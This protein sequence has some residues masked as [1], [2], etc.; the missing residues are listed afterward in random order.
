MRFAQGSYF[1]RPGFDNIVQTK[2]VMNLSNN[3]RTGSVKIAG[4]MEATR[5]WKER[6]SVEIIFKKYEQ[7]IN[8]NYSYNNI[9]FCKFDMDL[10]SGHI[11]LTI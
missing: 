2:L 5:Y 7:S 4:K 3:K 10:S 1:T 9:K 8:G 6:T 11:K